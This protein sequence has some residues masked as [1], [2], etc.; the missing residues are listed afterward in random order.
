MHGGRPLIIEFLPRFAVFFLLV[1]L[2]DKG[3]LEQLW[4]RKPL[5][6]RLIQETLE[7]GLEFWAH[8]LWEFN[9]IFDD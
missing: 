5:T 1:S 3:V 6:W 9:W 8:V 2:P 4:P 7:E